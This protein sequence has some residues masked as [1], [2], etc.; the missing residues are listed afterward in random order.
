MRVGSLVTF[1]HLN[2]EGEW[3]VPD[4]AIGGTIIAIEEDCDRDGYETIGT[5]TVRW[6]DGRVEQTKLEGEDETGSWEIADATPHLYANLYLHDRDYGGPEE[7]GW[8]YDTYTP[9]DGDWDETPPRYGHFTSVEEAEKAMVELRAWCE[10]EN[11]NRRSPSSVASEG[12]FCA[13][14]ESWPPEPMPARRPHYC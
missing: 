4:N 8:W 13:R 12:H 6:K 1:V 11:S 3:I 2:G 10:R 7:G 14:L 5:I 9:A